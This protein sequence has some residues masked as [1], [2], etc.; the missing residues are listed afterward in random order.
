VDAELELFAQLDDSDSTV[1][2]GLQE[3]M[4]ITSYCSLLCWGL[5]LCFNFLL[6]PRPRHRS[7]HY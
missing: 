4:T 2:A 1:T 3:S 7:V 6:F 5:A